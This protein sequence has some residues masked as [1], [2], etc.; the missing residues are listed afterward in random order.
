MIGDIQEIPIYKSSAKTNRY[1][2]TFLPLSSVTSVN[3]LLTQ[4]RLDT[5][6]TQTMK[7]LL[8]DAANRMTDQLDKVCVLMWDKVS[9]K[10]HLQYY[11]KKPKLLVLK[12]GERTARMSMLITHW[13]LCCKELKM[14]GKSLSHTTFV[15]VKQRTS[16]YRGAL[17]ML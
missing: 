4:I 8:K 2:G 7:D 16:S 14:A 10:L 6:V 11:A 5:G 17:K 12:I 3:K 9:A 13:Y 1:L 15:L